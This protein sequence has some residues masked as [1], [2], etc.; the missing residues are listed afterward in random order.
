MNKAGLLINNKQTTIE[1]IENYLALSFE[2]R[3]DIISEYTDIADLNLSVRSLN[4]LRRARINTIG[5]LL[6]MTADDLLKIR[7]MGKKS[8]KEIIM[9]LK[10]LDLYLKEEK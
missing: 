4:C 2:E 6:Q 10:N 8:R 7:N 3:Q 9:A 5:E 1:E